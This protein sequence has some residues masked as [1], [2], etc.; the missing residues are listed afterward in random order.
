MVV[1][2][3]TEAISQV[4]YMVYS[5]L[6]TVRSPSFQTKNHYERYLKLCEKHGIKGKAQAPDG[7]GQND[8]R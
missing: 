2:V 7:W 4:D 8:S 1:I 6:W 3:Q 5:W